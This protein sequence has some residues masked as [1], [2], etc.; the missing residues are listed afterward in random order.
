MRTCVL[1]LFLV[2]PWI[3]LLVWYFL[4]IF[5]SFLYSSKALSFS[6]PEK[7]KPWTMYD[8][9]PFSSVHT[10]IKWSSFSISRMLV[11]IYIFIQIP[12]K[13]SLKVS[14]YD[15]TLLT[16]QNHFKEEPQTF[17][18][19]EIR[20][21]IKAKQTGLASSSTRKRELVGKLLLSF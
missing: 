16:N 18:K 5:T 11:V 17:T 2:V 14:T 9:K 8:F 10:P 13:Q 21:A 4:V 12:I 6:K 3:G 1:C 20:K 15:H 7:V 19:Q